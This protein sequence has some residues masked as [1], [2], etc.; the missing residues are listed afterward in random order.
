MNLKIAQGKANAAQM[1]LNHR[2]SGGR[3]PTAIPATAYSTSPH[4]IS[5]SGFTLDTGFK[6]SVNLKTGIASFEGSPKNPVE[7]DV[8]TF[9]EYDM[10]SDDDQMLSQALDDAE[11]TSATSQPPVVVKKEP[12]TSTGILL[13]LHF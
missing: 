9:I 13:I 4:L 12:G 6:M 7:K 2:I 5:G 10:D 1:A 11:S 3:T 8:P